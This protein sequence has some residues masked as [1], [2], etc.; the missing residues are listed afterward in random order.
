MV[1]FD[2]FLS[3]A[4]GGATVAIVI[5]AFDEY[6]KE[7]DKAE[8]SFAGF[9]NIAKK[10]GIGAAVALGAFAT[11]SIRAAG[12]AEPVIGAFKQLA[13]NSDAFLTSLQ[14]S[15][16]GMVSNFELMRNANQALING[17][18]QN[19]LPEFFHNTAVV[20]D[21]VGV[22][23]TQAIDLITEALV[24]NNERSLTAIGINLD[25][26]SA[27]S[28]FAESVGKTSA[29]LTELEKKQVFQEELMRTLGERAV[30]LGDN[31]GTGLNDQLAKINAEWENMKVEVGTELIPVMME[32]M[33]VIIDNKEV[34]KILGDVLVA[35]AKGVGYVI[36]AV[37][38]LG[39]QT[40]Y[41]IDV[42]RN[43]YSLLSD[44]VG[45][46]NSYTFALE[47]S[48]SKLQQITAE[49]NTNTATTVANTNAKV[50]SLPVIR[51]TAKEVVDSR[52]QL[53][54]ETA[55]VDRNTS[56]WQRNAGART[57]ATGK[58]SSVQVG[59]G[60]T[61]GRD[62]QGRM[63]VNTALGYGGNVKAAFAGGAKVSGLGGTKF[64]SVSK[65]KDA[66]M[67]MTNKGKLFE[68]DDNDN[69]M[70]SASKKG[71]GMGGG[72]VVNVYNAG[73]LITMEQVV[74]TVERALRMKIMNN[75][76]L[77]L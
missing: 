27:Y 74:E 57:S 42:N 6:S 19:K 35:L 30:E 11:A 16:A 4:A 72:T 54:T 53:K 52:E 25:L 69:I 45:I 32:L 50:Q 60:V 26:E 7:L 47:M 49:T 23:A 13:D 3:G 63:V 2:S 67:F 8:K 31:L 77:G 46:Q 33:Q 75:V 73:N 21:A 44:G 34:F 17:I 76:S 15:T 24:K 59:G 18:E 20:A 36:D 22:D 64:G 65:K 39:T 48:N 37:R 1:S 29:E 70:L 55:E 58:I 62:A 5:K 61:A 14:T 28:K 56:A 38:W 51:D 71:G 43:F 9:G 10:I 66:A 12:E 40:G 68:F 41:A